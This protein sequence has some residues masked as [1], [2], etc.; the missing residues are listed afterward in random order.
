[1]PGASLKANMLCRHPNAVMAP[2]PRCSLWCALLLLLGTVSSAS[3]Q[4]LDK[5]VLTL[6][7]AKKIAAAAEAQKSDR[8]F[9]L[10]ISHP[11]LKIAPTTRCQPGFENLQQLSE[12]AHWPPPPIFGQ[13]VSDK[14]AFVNLN[15][16][17]R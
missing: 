16:S 7:A 8:K 1:M 12:K 11:E 10:G 9:L 15:L 14:V 17:R 6:A 5:K 4:V 2:S 3:A 13:R